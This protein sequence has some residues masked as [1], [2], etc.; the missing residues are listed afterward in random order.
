MFLLGALWFICFSG[1]CFSKPRALLPLLILFSLAG[2]GLMI[3]SVVLSIIGLAEWAEAS[4]RYTQGRAQAIFAL[5]ISG[6]FGLAFFGAAVRSAL[7]TGLSNQ[8]VPGATLTFNDLNFRFKAPGRPWMRTDATRISPEARVAFIRAEPEL[9]FIILADKTAN[10]GFS[11]ESMAE[12]A[13]GRLRGVGEWVRV[14]EKVRTNINGISALRVSIDV[15]LSG[16]PIHYVECF[17]ATNGWTYELVAWGRQEEALSVNREA[18]QLCSDFELMDYQKLSPLAA[19]HRPVDFVSTNHQFAVHCSDPGWVIWEDQ[20]KDCPYAN[21]GVLNQRDA[22][23]A[24]SAVSLMGLEPEPAVVYRGFLGVLGRTG[25]QK[26]LANARAI[27]RGH[28]EGIELDFERAESSGRL[29]TYRVQVLS[30]TNAAFLFMAWI[31]SDRSEKDKFLAEALSRVSFL[32]EPWTLLAPEQMNSDDKHVQRIA[33][34]SL[35]LVYYEQHHFERA[36]RFFQQAVALDTN[37]RDTPYLNN[38]VD[39]SLHTGN[40]RDALTELEVHQQMVDS[41]PGLKAREA[42]LQGRLGEIPLAL[43]NY[44]KLF[45]SGYSSE[46]DFREYV[47]ILTQV[48]QFDRALKESEDYL[49]GR[50]VPGV[51]LIQAG[52][53]KHQHRLA[54]ALALLQAQRQKHPFHAGIIYSLGDCYI[55]AGKPSEALSLSR[56]VLD[57]QGSSASLLLLKGRSEFALRWYREAKQSFEKALKE[58]PNDP[59]V[60]NW[61]NLASGALGE[62]ANSVVKDP[63]DPVAVPA[64]LEADLPAP[65]P[66]FGAEEGA[67]YS[68]RV[69]AISFIRGKEMKSTE[70][71][72]AH[73]LNAEGV[74]YFS[75]FQI[76]FHPLTEDLYVN[77]LEVRS[78]AGALISEGHPSDYFLL[79][80]A[81]TGMATSRKVLHIP[82]AGLRPGCRIEAVFTRR[83]F[84]QPKEFTF[85]PVTFSRPFPVQESIVYL[86][87]NTSEVRWASSPAIPAESLGKALCWRCKRPAV[88]RWEPLL[89]A[90]ADYAP[91]LWLSDSTTSWPA[92]VSEYLETVKPRLEWTADFGELARQLTQG[93]TNLPQKIAAVAGYVQTN[94]TYK[95][96]EFGRR[97]RD[98]E[99]LSQILHNKYGDCKDHAILTQQLLKAAGVP[100]ALALV[101][102]HSTIREDLPSLDQFNHMIVYVPGAA[103]D[104]F[105]DCTPKSADLRAGWAFGLA[106]RPALVLE[107]D[108]P[109]F[110]RIPEYPTNASVV[111]L[112]RT[113]QFTNQFETVVAEILE[114]EGLHAAFLRE[115]L[116]GRSSSA[117]RAYVV[118]ELV[119]TGG[120]L[121]DLKV[122]GLDDASAPLRF[123]VSSLVHGQFELLGA[124][125][126]GAPAFGIERT[127]F[128]VQP[129]EKRRAPY[130]TSSPLR[131][132]RSVS[133]TLPPG[134]SPAPGSG[135][136]R[137]VEN[138][139]VTSH[140]TLQT[141][142]RGWQLNSTLFESARRGPAEE[143]AAYRAAVRD[144]GDSLRPRLIAERSA[145]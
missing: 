123:Q 10:L 103:R 48:E 69:V 93:A 32:A 107:K 84:G 22:G 90:I 83:E 73:I 34:N 100:S 86:Q 26:D 76:G 95:A 58:A 62:G 89:P 110:V 144:A 99:P 13:L 145:R 6:L 138:R 56:E 85:L 91:S 143:Y 68:R 52:I 104:W 38:F 20:R 42:F 57:Q 2:C 141:L 29:F 12:S 78:A 82:I 63:I 139:F 24:V 77:K 30:D 121:L 51:R 8:S 108:A 14:E 71:V 41:Q 106:G 98:P 15:Q 17:C 53:L 66:D 122:E 140:T 72:M 129:A 127:F 46:D 49:K 7:L 124:Q 27:H 125:L 55:A 19:R 74:S 45:S 18:A 118:S 43:T 64:E 44:A 130:E 23:L 105:V 131:L 37:E 92:L 39:A 11:A 67:Y 59:D 101:N 120:E 126:A 4:A 135:G 115:F 119:S 94:Y 65:A 5:V 112:T 117:R 33:L 116:R 134:F 16:K 21:F 136:D 81:S 25:D 132:E 142:A 47:Q 114:F 102:P 31:N 79:D 109:R 61:L 54:E 50:D 9:S 3:T 137:K 97:A 133:I 35:G 36:A 111:R 28:F 128:N 75:T 87:G 96:I 70:L 88:M 60:K 40:Y 113:I 80:D 1:I